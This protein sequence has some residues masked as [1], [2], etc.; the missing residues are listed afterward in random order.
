[1]AKTTHSLYFL[2]FFMCFIMSFSCVKGKTWCVAKEGAS[3][4]RLNEFINE[5]CPY[6]ACE[7][8]R[9]G[10]KCFFPDNAYNHGSY[11]LNLKYRFT[12]QCDLSIATLTVTDPSVLGCNYP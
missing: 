10:G 7:P 12:G 2:G 8:I 1:M 6:L 3:K 9:R 11:A 5:V 4:D